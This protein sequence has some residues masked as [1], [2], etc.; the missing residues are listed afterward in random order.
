MK[1]LDSQSIFKIPSVSQKKTDDCL[2]MHIL[3]SF[4]V[5]KLGKLQRQKTNL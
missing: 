4:F 1:Q 5:C 3:N 2:K